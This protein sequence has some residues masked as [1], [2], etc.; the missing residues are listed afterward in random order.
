MKVLFVF[1]IG[2]LDGGAA[3]VWMNLLDRLPERGVEPFVVIPQDSDGTLVAELEKREISWWDTFYTW[4]VTTDPHPHSAKRR[5]ARA[6][7]RVINS[8]AEQDIGKLIDTWGIELVYICDGTI[9]AGLAAAHARSLPVVWH[10]HQFI[11]EDVGIS[12]IDSD[13]QVRATLAKANRII[14]VSRAIAADMENRFPGISVRAIPNG[15]SKSR[16]G[17]KANVLQGEAVTFTL[18]GR[19]DENKR[20]RD[21][22]LAFSEIA[23]E[24]PRAHLKIVGTGQEELITSLQ[25]LVNELPA[26]DRIELCGQ[27]DDIVTIWNSTDVALNCSYSEGCSMVIAEAMMS[28]CLVLCSTAPGNVEIVKEGTGIL[29]ERRNVG[30]L[31]RRMRWVLEHSDEA[32]VLARAG[33]EHAKRMFDIDAQV[34]AVYEL[35][36]EVL[37]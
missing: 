20:T 12:F 4:W 5:I 14:A 3:S 13:R 6:G 18:V 25:G 35:F 22:V 37:S 15:I 24:F 26:R 1:S 16:I 21:A 9:T 23:E 29:Y 11:R 27:R 36:A 31:A 33:K 34:D 30:D 7:A 32:G 17:D 28:G 8:R 2:K 10:F 19:I